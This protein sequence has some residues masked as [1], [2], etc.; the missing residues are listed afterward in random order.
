MS[1]IRGDVD[2][3]VGLTT[4]QFVPP[5]DVEGLGTRWMLLLTVGL[6]MMVSFF[7]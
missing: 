2:A 1:N 3:F 7:V 5:V 4:Q 6:L